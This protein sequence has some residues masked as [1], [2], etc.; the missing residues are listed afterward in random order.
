MCE[1]GKLLIR[2][3][4]LEWNPGIEEQ[5]A[6]AESH[7]DGVA[8]NVE[9][10]T[11]GEQRVE[12]YTGQSALG[13]Q[14]PMLLDDVEEVAGCIVTGEYYRLAAEGTH[15]RAADIKDVA[16]AGQPG[17]V[18]IACLRHQPIAQAGTVNEQWH[19]VCLAEVVDSL[20]FGSLVECAEFGGGGDIDNAGYD[21][22]LIDG[23][24]IEAVVKVVKIFGSHLTVVLG[25]GDDFVAAG[26]N[27]PRLMYV[28]VA[29][30][31]GYDALVARQHTINNGGIGLRA[32]H[33]EI[34]VGIGAL[35][36]LSDFLAGLVAPDVGAVG[37]TL[38]LVGVDK[39][40]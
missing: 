1:Y 10:E 12:L 6:Q 13:Q 20:D 25:Q 19:F 14:G 4:I 31:Y 22:V 16:M 33:E 36:G 24:G 34:D 9:I 17:Q 7:T 28:D 21:H 29:G 32:A 27:G 11:V 38:H 2:W 8:G 35:A 3:R 5:L 15:L 37:G 40:L 30:I 18:E 26:L 39:M 23:V